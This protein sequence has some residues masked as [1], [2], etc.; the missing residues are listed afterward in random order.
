MAAM[1]FRVIAIACAS[2]AFLCGGP[3]SAVA[4]DPPS[5]QTV[6][7]T[8]GKS[9]PPSPPPP[10]SGDGQTAVVTG[11]FPPDPP[12]DSKRNSPQT[13]TKSSSQATT[14]SST[15]T[16]SSPPPPSAEPQQA[17]ATS[18]TAE[19]QPAHSHVAHPRRAP[20]HVSVRGGL[21]RRVAPLPAPRGG[22]SAV[23]VRPV[24]LIIA[25]PRGKSLA[26]ADQHAAAARAVRSAAGRDWFKWVVPIA[27][28]MG[29]LALF[30]A[31]RHAYWRWAI[32]RSRHPVDAEIA[33]VP[34]DPAT[35]KEYAVYR[36]TRRLGR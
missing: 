17:P 3:S 32:H 31:V 7:I 15:Q 25:V 23:E 27:A 18:Q 1:H 21:S 33:P 34:G 9:S 29:L 16:A 14:K 12:P 24:D 4:D 36:G 6:V 20:S 22:A 30:A 35:A 11:P 10:P 19:T 13:P 26:V 2:A 8:L 28:L 5:G